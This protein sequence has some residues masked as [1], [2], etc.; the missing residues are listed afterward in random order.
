MYDRY[1][2]YELSTA[3]IWILGSIF[4]QLFEGTKPY[5]EERVKSKALGRVMFSRHNRPS[6]ECIELIEWM[7]KV[8]PNHRPQSVNRVMKHGWFGWCEEFGI[9]FY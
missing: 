6:N 9:E 7:L 3:Q 5:P 2:P 1:I 8:E 4:Y